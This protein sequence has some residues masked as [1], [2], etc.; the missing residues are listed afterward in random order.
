MI[1]SVGEG[2]MKPE[3]FLMFSSDSASFTSTNQLL[4]RMMMTLFHSSFQKCA[5]YFDLKL[6]WTSAVSRTFINHI[7]THLTCVSNMSVTCFSQR[8][9][10]SSWLLRSCSCFSR[11]VTSLR[12][13]Q[14]PDCAFFSWLR[15]RFRTASHLRC[16]IWVE[17]RHDV[18]GLQ[19][20]LISASVIL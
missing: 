17:K 5:F 13:C 6:H 10:S 18:S 15:R 9:S 4:E 1:R 16:W 3:W 14:W 12:S 20:C 19:H 7:R 8:W 11:C 2:F